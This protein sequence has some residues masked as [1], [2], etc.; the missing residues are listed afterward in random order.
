MK[1]WMDALNRAI[2]TTTNFFGECTLYF[3]IF[4]ESHS[5]VVGL[6]VIWAPISYISC[7][8]S[9][10]HFVCTESAS[11]FSQVLID[12]AASVSLCCFVPFQMT[13]TGCHPRTNL[14][15]R[16]RN[17]RVGGSSPAH[18]VLLPCRH[19]CT[20]GDLTRQH[21]PQEDHQSALHRDL[22]P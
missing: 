2:L 16:F 18:G 1:D 6:T 11:E 3:Q 4:F 17:A 12:V 9:V 10:T 14:G 15:F 13:V 22:Q 7:V 21:L 8:T 20:A 5:F 19:S